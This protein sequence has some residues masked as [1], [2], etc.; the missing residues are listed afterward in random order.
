MPNRVCVKV[1]KRQNPQ[2]YDTPQTHW[3]DTPERCVLATKCSIK[4]PTWFKMFNTKPA[5]YL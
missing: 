4:C 2:L 3:P 5:Q 1:E